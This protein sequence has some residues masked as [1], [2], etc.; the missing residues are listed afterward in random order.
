MSLFRT[1]RFLPLFVTQFCGALNDNLLKNAMIMLITYRMATGAHD[2]QWLVTVAGGLFV[3]PFFLFSAMAGQMADKYDRAA[4]TRV[5]KLVEIGIMAVAVAGFYL[6]SIGILL[7]ALAGMGV[8]S[9]FFGPIKYA[10]LPQQLKPEELLE[11][12][13]LVEAGTFL[14]ILMGTIAGGALVLRANGETLVC[15]ALVAVA[16]IGYLSSRHIAAATPSDP[17]LR[18]NRNLFRETI[19]I[20]SQSFQ[21][22]AIKR[23]I[24]G[25]SWFWFVGATLLAQFAPYVKDVLHA[26][27]AVVTLLLTVFSV[28]V[29]LGSYACDRLLRGE[30]QATYVPLAALGL[31]L[32]GIDLYF[33]SQ[34]ATAVVATAATTESLQSLR[35]FLSV[36]ANWRVLFDLGGMAICGGIYIVPLYAIMQHRSQ[37]AHRARVIASNNVMNALFMVVSALLTI[38]ML[39]L[40]FTIPEIFLSVAVANG[41]VALYICRL[42]PDALVRSVLRSVLTLLYHVELRHPERYTDAGS[43]VLIVA[44]H[45]SFLDAVLI[46]AFL[47]EKLHFAVNTHVARQWWMKPVMA[48]VNAFPLDPTNPLAAKS[49]IDLLKRDEKCM[50]FPEGRLTVTGALMKIYEGPGMIAD[51]SDAQ[52]LPIRIDGAQYS[53]FSRLRGKVRIRWFP[54]ITMTV[55]PPQRFAIPDDIKGRARRQMASAQLY[56]VMSEMMFRSAGTHKTLF[57]ALLSASEVHGRHRPIVEDIERKPLRYGA[58][59][60]RVFTLG[61]VLL[62]GHLEPADAA[63]TGEH[64]VSLEPVGVMLPNTVAASVVFFALQSIGRAPAMLNFTNGA[65]QTAQ[66]CN[67][68]KLETVLTSRRFVTMA[69][70]EAII[71]ALVAAGVKIVYLEDLPTTV[72]WHDKAY[73]LLASRFPHWAYARNLRGAG[74]VAKPTTDD[75]APSNHALADTTAVILYTSGSEG[76]PKGVVLSHHN[77]LANC[78]QIASRVDFG[79]QDIVLNVLP[80]FHSFGLTGGTLLPILSG[81]K[82]FYYPSPLHYRIVPELIYDTNA[83][84]MFGTDTFLSAYAR[85]AHPYDLHSVRYIF[86]GAEKLRE[87]TRRVYA[88]KYGVR[89]FEGYGATEMSPVISLNTPMQNRPGTVGR[90]L[91]GIASRLEAVPGI[92]NAGLLFVKGP[93]VMK[94]YMKADAPG[95]LQAPPDGWYD[96]GD[97]VSID[98]HGYVT[99]QGRQKRFAKIAGEMV[100]LTAVESTISALW[101]DQQHAAVS[102]PD[103]RK[104]EQI[105]LLTTREDARRDALLQWFQQRQVSELALPRRIIHLH[106]LPTLGTGKTDYQRAKQLAAQ[107]D[108]VTELALEKTSE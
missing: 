69:K 50:I 87:D 79:P 31:T 57:Q 81:I 86:A 93:N 105:V 7:A 92:D 49:L 106:K 30:V 51:R 90:L 78:G 2:A 59:L 6:H 84:I 82:A 108:P 101:P 40:H 85:A 52:L 74:Y 97:I 70:L 99:I 24:L 54:R 88:D 60:L 23:C 95:V 68:A 55:L 14:A 43:R 47:P 1:K 61:R 39:A 36:P 34:H 35:T 18:I 56:D 62:R 16:V 42:L 28:G 66:A 8:H 3:L 53:P 44:N 72:R 89:I 26:D 75:D 15:I 5:I 103:S 91:P 102:L 13:A 107:A 73:G 38:V 29:G 98:E 64:T 9:T 46:A 83:T 19:L 94:G 37:P 77:I 17:S 45:T 41:A 10:L 63:Q 96:T 21:D 20:V 67:T 80:M 11:G 100:S 25:S 71:D 27:P 76:S 48:L 22:K 4:M 58:F 12:N 104:G 65:A 33:A 32:F